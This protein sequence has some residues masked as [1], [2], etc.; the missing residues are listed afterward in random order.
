MAPAIVWFR[1]DLRLTDNPALLAAAA[2]GGPVIPVFIWAPEEEGAWA[3]GRGA[4]WWL[5]R[6]LSA[7][8]AALQERGSRLLFRRGPSLDALRALAAE[9]GAA[10]VYWNRRFEPAAVGRDAAVRA[11]LAAAGLQTLTGNAGLLFEP[12]AVHTRAGRP[13]QVFGSFWK[14]CLSLPQP[15][16]PAPAPAWLPAPAQWPASEAG[17]PADPGFLA[18]PARPSAPAGAWAPGEAGACRRFAA[19]LAQ[20]LATYPDTRDCP[21]GLGTST[22]SPHL[23]WGELGPRQLWHEVQA[24]AAM[25]ESAGWARGAGTFLRE[26]GWREFAYHLLAHFPHTAGQ[27][28]RPDFSRFPWAADPAALR[29]WQNGETGYPVVDAGLRELRETGWMHNRARMV[30]ASFLVKHLLLPWTD[31]AA[32]F[33]DT[34]VDADLANNTL[35]WQWTAGCGADAA[36]FFRIFNPVV[37]GEKFDPHGDYVR[38]W[39]PELAGLPA[40][41]I[42]RPWAAPPAV[43]AAAKVAVGRT[44]P[45]PAV[46]HQFA[47]RRA[48]AALQSLKTRTGGG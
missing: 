22:L 8:D 3:P 34:L 31:G 17:P 25:A 28:L 15:P 46:D 23:H 19:F 9:T 43:L 29:R 4:R 14:A 21:A 48:L 42:H 10:A 30:A 35:N 37:Q 5:P 47:R 36:P 11:G 24:R 18:P 33:W 20:D 2:S 41:Y 40:Q 12:E 44:Y 32:W 39:V 13:F 26:V 16:A 1:Q 27:P 45:A 7:L 6:S 38:R